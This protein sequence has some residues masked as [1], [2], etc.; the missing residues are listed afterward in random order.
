MTLVV[1][2]IKYEMPIT[3]PAIWTVS[4]S[5]ITSGNNTLT[6]E[7]SKVMELHIKCRTNSVYPR[8][9]YYT[10]SL[11]FAYAGSS[12]I[13]LN[14]YT[15]LESILSNLGGKE[16][17][18]TLPDHISIA[19]KAS[20][21][22]KI[23]ASSIQ[24]SCE[25]SIYGFCPKTQKPFIASIRPI[26]TENGIDF[27]IEYIYASTE[28]LQFSLLGDEKTVISKLIMEMA[29]EFKPTDYKHWAVPMRTIQVLVEKSIYPSIG[30]GLQLGVAYP[31]E[32]RLMALIKFLEDKTVT[33][34]FRNMD[35]FSDIGLDIGDCKFSIDIMS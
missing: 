5:K 18:N 29:A 16:T 23:Y 32:F 10:G 1:S 17:S 30:G 13:A 8:T 3:I 14:T 27:D 25:I 6:L 26:T 2:W 34:K 19:E 15:M 20:K 24:G 35:V 22:L 31:T 4:D 33:A 11:G 7:G 12:L 21:I 28:G 9:I